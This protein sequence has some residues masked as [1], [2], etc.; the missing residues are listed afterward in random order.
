MRDHIRSRRVV[1][2]SRSD[3]R[4]RHLFIKATAG[5]LL[6][7]FT[8]PWLYSYWPGVFIWLVGGAG[9]WILWGVGRRR[10]RPVASLEH[11]NAMSDDQFTEYAAA[12]LAAQGY[13]VQHVGRALDPRI[14]FL[15]RR[16]TDRVACRIE[17]GDRPVGH[18]PVSLAL[19]G[20]VAHGCSRAL[21]VSNSSFTL[22]AEG[23]AKAEGCALVDRDGLASLVVQHRRGHRVLAF[24]TASDATDPLNRRRKRAKPKP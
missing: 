16:G 22:R 15:L 3:R 14:D 2:G 18:E 24:Q 6:F 9:V 11:V 5:V 10:R 13:T 20:M 4:A 12:L 1:R 8:V 19:A 21:I 23:V 7:M 17:H